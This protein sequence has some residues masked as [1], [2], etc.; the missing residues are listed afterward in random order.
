MDVTVCLKEFEKLSHRIGITIRYTKGGPSG[1]CM[2]KGNHIL[3]ID[4]TLDKRDQIEV[5]LHEFKTLDLEGIFI[6]P[7]IRRLLGLEDEG[8][9]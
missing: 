1:L 5:F 9:D 2:V 6:V 7:L 4:E 3:F 8:L